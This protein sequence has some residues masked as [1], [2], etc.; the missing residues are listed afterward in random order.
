MYQ[1]WQKDL[2]NIYLT[3]DQ[4]KPYTFTDL[5]ELYN[6]EEVIQQEKPTEEDQ[7]LRV[8]PILY[9][10]QTQTIKLDLAFNNVKPKDWYFVLD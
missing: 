7:S 8:K 4:L 1:Y 6:L 9:L 3:Y 2:Q 10:I 5:I